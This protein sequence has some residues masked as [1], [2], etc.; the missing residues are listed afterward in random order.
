MKNIDSGHGQNV[1]D[2]HNSLT[3]TTNM[4]VV[5]QHRKTRAE[6][7]DELGLF[8]NAFFT[9]HETDNQSIPA[10]GL[11]TAAGQM[12][13]YLITRFAPLI[14][15]VWHSIVKR[16]TDTELAR[17]GLIVNV[18]GRRPGSRF[19]NGTSVSRSGRVLTSTPVGQSQA[20]Y[21]ISQ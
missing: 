12:H 6:L 11:S 4:E 14:D 16:A 1:Q 19:S 21:C 9:P 8:N 18:G 13:R 3:Q 17:V 20:R 10:T 7:F 2:N 15:S 5:T